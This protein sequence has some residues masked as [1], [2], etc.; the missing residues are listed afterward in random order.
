[1]A[2]EGSPGKRYHVL[3]AH[4]RSKA[5]RAYSIAGG[6]ATSGDVQDMTW[7]EMSGSNR[8][9]NTLELGAQPNQ[10]TMTGSVAANFDSFDANDD[11]A[12]MGSATNLEGLVDFDTIPLSWGYLDQL[13]M[14]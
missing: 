7:M 1:M 4:L 12:T 10:T 2:P 5:R 14:C 13:G 6:E 9:E 8:Q 3:L 11:P